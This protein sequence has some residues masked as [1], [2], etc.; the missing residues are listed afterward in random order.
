[1]GLFLYKTNVNPLPDI[2]GVFSHWECAVSTV[3]FADLL[4]FLSF[5]DFVP[6][7]WFFSSLTEESL[8]TSRLLYVFTQ[9]LS[10][11]CI[12]HYIHT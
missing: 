1:M 12:F 9:Y 2:L 8:D 11:N 3:S 5:T 10:H 7:F 4:Q 6:N